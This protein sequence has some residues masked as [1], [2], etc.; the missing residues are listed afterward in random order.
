VTRSFGWLVLTAVFALELAA[1]AA[2]FVWGRGQSGWWLGLLA[3]GAVIVAWA[4]F[5]SPRALYGSPVVRPVVKVLVFGLSS[6]GL[7]MAGHHLA[8][9]LLVTA[10]VVVHALAALPP[11]RALT[12]EDADG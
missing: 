8:A 4:L 7:W 6:L 5:A 11:V 1:V 12:A 10:A 2:A 9:I 3:A